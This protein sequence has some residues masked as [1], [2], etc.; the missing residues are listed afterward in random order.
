VQRLLAQQLEDGGTDVAARRPAAAAVPV[1]AGAEL[2]AA[3]VRA[4]SRPEFGPESWAE[5]GA[6]LRPGAAVSAWVV[7]SAG[8]AELAVGLH[9]VLLLTYG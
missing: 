6:E 7:G 4:E 8:S 3:L 9:K 1:A 2:R 5:P